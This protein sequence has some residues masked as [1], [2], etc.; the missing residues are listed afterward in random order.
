MSHRTHMLRPVFVMGVMAALAGAATCGDDVIEEQ[1]PVNRRG[2][3]PMATD[4]GTMFDAQTLGR[5]LADWNGQLTVRADALPDVIA[6][7][8]APLR[9][10]ADERIAAVDR[11]VG[12]SDAQRKKLETAAQSDMRRLVD[13]VVEARATYAGRM[14]AF[15]PNT[16]RYDQDSLKLMQE[17]S[18]DSQRCRQLM[19]EAFGPQSL[20]ARGVVSTLDEA[21]A[22]TYAA[23]M[24]ERAICR[25]KAIV[26]AGLTAFDDRLGLTQKQHDSITAV[27]VADPPPADDEA[28][29][30]A[31]AVVVAGRLASLGDEKLATLLD[32]RQQKLVAEVAQGRPMAAGVGGG[33]QFVGGN[34]VGGVRIEVR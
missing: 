33:A 4:L 8:L 5:K 23:V 20:L 31:A 34:A 24:R 11:I 25:W 18:Q 28:R 2:R 29:P 1:G 6:G 10:R 26:A 16:G 14:T 19:Q 30:V 17:M 27:L 21:Q 3:Q 7:R 12:L 22:Q 13:A 15:D 32:P 9:Q